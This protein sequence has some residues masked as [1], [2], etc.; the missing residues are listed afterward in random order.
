MNI[1]QLDLNLLKVL[2]VLLQTA[3]TKETAH[4][5]QISPSAV[6][7][8]LNRLRSVLNDPLFRRE[9]NLQVPTPYALTL[10]EKLIPLFSALN[11]DLFKHTQNKARVFRIVIPPALNLLLTPQLAQLSHCHNSKLECVTFE[12]RSWRDEVLQGSIDLVL[13]VGDYQNPVSALCYTHVGNT[14]LVVLYGEP[15]RS[16]LSNQQGLTLKALTAFNHVYCHPWPQSENE[17]DRQLRR[18]GLNRDIGFQCNDYAQILPAIKSAPLIAVVPQP[19]FDAMPDKSEVY[20]LDLNDEKSIG[21]LFMM[22]RNSTVLWKQQI[23]CALAAFL[24]RYYH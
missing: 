11:E 12:R 4:I 5:L 16:Q 14:Q 10:K 8:A 21:G 15:L 3:S 6:S 2:H 24:K 19:W 7:H 20:K 13:A 22:H 23:I 9:N 17:I 1:L 18:M